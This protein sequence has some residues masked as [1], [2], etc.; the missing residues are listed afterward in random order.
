[1]KER[2][3][4]IGDLLAQGLQEQEARHICGSEPF[5]AWHKLARIDGQLA[6]QVLDEEDL[7]KIV[8]ELKRQGLPKEALSQFNGYADA[9][10]QLVWHGAV[11]QCPEGDWY[12]NTLVSA[13]ACSILL[14]L[15][16]QA[17]GYDPELE[18]KRASAS[19]AATLGVATGI[20]TV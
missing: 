17:W 4:P 1:M 9:I 5:I 13:V 7:G 3:I 8:G 6:L 12:D 18:A 14:C 20:E 15:A 11:Q 16:Q 19:F 10:S 2:L